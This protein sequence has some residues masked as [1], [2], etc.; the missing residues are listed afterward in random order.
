MEDEEKWTV[1]IRDT[2]QRLWNVGLLAVEVA[3]ALSTAKKDTTIRY[4]GVYKS[5]E[6]FE[7]ILR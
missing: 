1:I 7:R 6:F 5:P 2:P 3:S 4:Y